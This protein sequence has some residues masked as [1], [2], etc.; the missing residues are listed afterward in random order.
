MRTND[1]VVYLH[2]YFVLTYKLA[3]CIITIFIIFS[4]LQLICGHK[5]LISV[6]LLCTPQNASNV[7][8]RGHEILICVNKVDQKWPQKASFCVQNTNS[9]PEMNNLFF[10]N[11][12][13]RA[14]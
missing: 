1:H 5:M 14:S 6:L 10:F 7:L 8:I 13:S 4:S 9:W 3:F 11:I 12:M 2:Q